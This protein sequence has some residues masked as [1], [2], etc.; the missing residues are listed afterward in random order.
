MKEILCPHCGTAIQVDDTTYA[1]ILSQVRDKAYNE[2][3]DKSARNLRQQLEAE[4]G[5]ELAEQIA[6]KDREIAALNEKIARADEIIASADERKK[7]EIDSLEAAKKAEIA[8]VLAQ[9]DIKINEL[10]SRLGQAEQNTQMR[11]LQEQSE[12]RTQLEAKE[13]EI[14]ELRHQ[15]E[16]SAN[17]AAEHENLLKQHH[18]NEIKMRDEE[19]EQ[20]RNYKFRQT[21][22]LIGEDLEQHCSRT[23]ESFRSMGL[24][25]NAFFGKDNNVVEGTKGD[26]IFR[27]FIDGVQYVSIMFE[28][29]NEA[30]VTKNRHKND[31][32]LDKLH[33]DRNKKKCEYA[34]LVSMLEQDNEIYNAGIVDKSHIYSNMLVIRPQFFMPVIRLISEA[35]RKAFLDRAEITKELELARSHNRDFTGYENRVNKVIT[36]FHNLCTAS[37]KKLASATSGIDKAIEGLE[38]QIETLRN[39]KNDLLTSDS[40]LTRADEHLSEKL[41]VRHLTHGF[42]TV[43]KLIEEAAEDDA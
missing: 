16:S 43:R 8:G 15:L 19:I 36:D 13:R 37:Q 35:A 9:K 3:L 39:I 5:K 25:P 6:V 33:S 41:T 22:K 28:M 12:S 26:F 23:F 18:A 1:A 27:D 10:T 34:V 14:I 40:K 20:L 42:P 24:F 7:A 17:S 4:H 29:K 32:F 38:K 21:V 31:D 2:E 30:D 11:I